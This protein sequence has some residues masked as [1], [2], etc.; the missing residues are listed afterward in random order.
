MRPVPVPNSSSPATTPPRPGASSTSASPPASATAASS[1]VPQRPCQKPSRHI[2]TS[3]RNRATIQ[4]AAITLAG[5][6]LSRPARRW[7]KMGA[8]LDEIR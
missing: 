7:G 3:D 6:T 4:L 5:T 1:S 8:R 2:T